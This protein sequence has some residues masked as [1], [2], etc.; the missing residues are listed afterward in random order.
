MNASEAVETSR[1]KGDS[2]WGRAI[3]QSHS[4]VLEEEWAETTLIF[5]GSMKAPEEI[6]VNP[7][8]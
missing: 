4:V 6:F 8:R 7:L 2:S 3:P 5:C 1:N